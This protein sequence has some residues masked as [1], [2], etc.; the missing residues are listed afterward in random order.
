MRPPGTRGWSTSWTASPGEASWSGRPLLPAMARP[1][2]GPPRSHDHERAFPPLFPRAP[3]PPSSL[4]PPYYSCTV[5]AHP[6]LTGASFRVSWG[7]FSDCCECFR[8]LAGKSRG[9]AIC[10][11]ARPRS[12]E[13]VGL[14]VWSDRRPL[15]VIVL[16]A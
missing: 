13:V 2:G 14:W 16:S 1:E 11:H 9:Y 8:G 3:F 12:L 5:P 6:T 4:T 15:G 7:D 10:S